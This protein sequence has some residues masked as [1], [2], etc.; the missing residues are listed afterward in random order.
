MSDNTLEAYYSNVFSLCHLHRFCTITEYENMMPFELS[1]YTTL[2]MEQARKEEDAAKQQ[3][4]IEKAI[5]E[6]GF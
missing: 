6:Q 1:V 4:S 2:I 5:R 3:A